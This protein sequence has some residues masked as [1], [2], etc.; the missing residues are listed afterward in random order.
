MGHAEIFNDIYAR[1]VHWHRGS[2]DGSRPD[3]AAP[4]MRFLKFFLDINRISSVLDAGCGDWQFS[5]LMDWSGLRYTGLDVSSVVLRNT[6]TFARP[7]VEFLELDA[8]RDELPAADL[9]V[10]KDVMQHWSNDDIQAFLPR[11]GKYRFAL[12]TNYLPAEAADINRAV[13]TG[14]WRGI[15]PALAPFRLPGSF[16]FW[17]AGPDPKGVFLW[18]NPDPGAA[19]I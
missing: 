9:L 4:Y 19:P 14:D 5:R 2:G 8:T 10:M 13:P 18:Q 15:N 16:V 17:Y 7:G 6:R 3:N 12:L 1:N 11:L